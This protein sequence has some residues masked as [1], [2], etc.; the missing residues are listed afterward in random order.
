[1]EAIW[2]QFKDKPA[3]RRW[4]LDALPSVGTP[5]IVKFI[6]EKFLAGELTLPEFIQALVVALHM[7]TADLETMQL[8][9]S[10]ATH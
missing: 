2:A 7:V 9:A 1:I 10:L 3:Y 6:K 5:V 8:T 4:L